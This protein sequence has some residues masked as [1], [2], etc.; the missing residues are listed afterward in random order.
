VSSRKQQSRS[1]ALSF[2]EWG[3]MGGEGLTR[4][5]V[6]GGTLFDQSPGAE[7]QYRREGLSGGR[8]DGQDRAE[9]QN[10]SGRAGSKHNKV[11]IRCMGVQYTRTRERE[12]E[13]IES[14]GAAH[15]HHNP[16]HAGPC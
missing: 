11:T 9:G 16:M 2:C 15:A 13:V 10:Y 1:I 3:V 12:D 8:H 14:A 5:V 4:K 7:W 6:D